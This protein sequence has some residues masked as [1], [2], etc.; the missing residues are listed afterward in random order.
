MIVSSLC[1]ERECIDYPKSVNPDN[2]IIAFWV[3]A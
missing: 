2:Q 3:S 1:L